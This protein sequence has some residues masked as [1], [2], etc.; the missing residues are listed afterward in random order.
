[1]TEETIP[2]FETAIANDGR[3]ME[4][5][6]DASD[7]TKDKLLRKV[8]EEKGQE[9]ACWPAGWQACLPAGWLA[10][11]QTVLQAA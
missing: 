11:G 10:R 7:T 6:Q 4:G 8:K 3:P 5:K 1:M 2:P 9:G